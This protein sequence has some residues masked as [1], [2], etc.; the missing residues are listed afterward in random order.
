MSDV[1]TLYSTQ[2][3]NQV[4]QIVA[5]YGINYIIVGSLERQAY[6]ATALEKF[7]SIYPVALKSGDNVIY[8]T[9]GK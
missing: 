6:S 1:D 8:K 2:D 5:K 7:G 4:K 3:E 9:G